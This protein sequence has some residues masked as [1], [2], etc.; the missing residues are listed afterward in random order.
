MINQ[1]PEQIARDAIDKQ[2]LASG[3]IILNLVARLRV[4]LYNLLAL[5]KVLMKDCLEL[6]LSKLEQSLQK[7]PTPQIIPN[8]RRF[9]TPPLFLYLLLNYA[10]AKGSLFLVDTNDLGVWKILDINIFNNDKFIIGSF[11]AE[12]GLSK[13]L[14]FREE[15]DKR[16]EEFNRVLAA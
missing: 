11:N 12:V 13:V 14:I 8:T 15:K 16:I 1:N 2:L 4:S 5:P 10:I 9:F 7:Q 6:T 3:W